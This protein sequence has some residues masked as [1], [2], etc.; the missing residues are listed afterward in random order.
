MGVIESPGRVHHRG[1]AVVRPRNDSAAL[2]F[3]TSRMSRQGGGTR[4]SR[5][6]RFAGCCQI[7]REALGTQQYRRR[8]QGLKWAHFVEMVED[9]RGGV[10]DQFVGDLRGGLDGASRCGCS[11][12]EGQSKSRLHW[13][14]AS[15]KEDWTAV[16]CVP[17][18]VGLPVFDA[19]KNNLW[20][21]HGIAQIASGYS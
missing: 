14:L 11:T 5:R 2:L 16:S 19:N 15:R 7:R 8:P 17:V 1:T 18:G 4:R 20:A 12:D 3:L 9:T 6:H 13:L 10:L 21:C